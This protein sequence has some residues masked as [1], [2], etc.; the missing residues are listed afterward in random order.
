MYKIIVDTDIGS[1][2]DDVMALSYLLS[3]KD[4]EILGITTVTGD[5]V[6]RARI[7][8]ALI[9]HAGKNI[10]IY[11]G[12]ASPLN[13]KQ[14]QTEVPQLIGVN[15]WEHQTDF[16]E[17]MELEFLHDL[18]CSNPGE[19]II[20]SI[21]PMTNIARLFTKYPETPQLIKGFYSM[22]GRFGIEENFSDLLEWNVMLDPEAAKIVYNTP[23][24]VHRC[25]GSNITRQMRMESIDVKKH[26]DT[27]QFKIIYDFCRVWFEK[28]EFM[29]FHD[30]LTAAVID[31]PQLCSFQRGSI[32]IDEKSVTYWQPEAPGGHNS[33]A[34]DVKKEQFF[35]HFFTV[36]KNF[37]K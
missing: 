6:S 17:H 13:I 19:V 11:P 33:V 31:N 25:V 27:D 3:H 36:L 28:R 30:P 22:S 4:F 26:F 12:S 7:A 32:K 20:L 23:I 21:G 1:D 18:I 5:P 14:I 2:I 34:V 10:P 9:K 24:P 35:T 16:K 15:R 29:T 8:S 37:G